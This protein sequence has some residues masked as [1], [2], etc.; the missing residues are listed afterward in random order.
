MHNGTNKA[1]L[2][3]PTK[4]F[5]KEIGRA[6][7]AEAAAVKYMRVDHRSRDVPVPQEFLDRANVVA[8][9]E[10]VRRKR[11]PQAV[12]CGRFGNSTPPDSALEN[13]L[14]RRLMEMIP[15]L[16]SSFSFKISARCR[17]DPLPCP[18]PVGIRILSDQRIR[19]NNPPS[20]F[21]HIF[22]MQ[23][24]NLI[25]MPPERFLHRLRQYRPAI[26]STLSVPHQNFSPCEVEIFDPQRQGC[27]EP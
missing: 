5:S 13:T 11:V 3:L 20:P 22:F 25:E 16:N 12:R 10:Q 27:I 23:L 14:D 18:F 21:A 19:Q 7:D 24:L 2:D 9:F 15:A 1:C 17:K 4:L 6:A 26:L 8:P